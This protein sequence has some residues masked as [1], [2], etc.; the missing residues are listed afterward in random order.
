MER[1]GGGTE[2]ACPPAA[3][4]VW[5]GSTVA[6]G[7][8]Q[9]VRPE[10]SATGVSYSSLQRQRQT[11]TRRA[12]GA[13]MR[14]PLLHRVEAPVQQEERKDGGRKEGEARDEWWS[15]PGAC[16]QFLGRR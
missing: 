11:G 7:S 2:E 12:Y 4:G 14:G 8:P 3:Q 9:V 5:A 16:Q 6:G 1:L 15:S 13:G 10:L